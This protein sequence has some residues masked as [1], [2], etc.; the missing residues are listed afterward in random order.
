MSRGLGDVY[1]RQH[2]RSTVF[3]FSPEG[4]QHAVHQRAV[5]HRADPVHGRF[6]PFGIQAVTGKSAERAQCL[7]LQDTAATTRLFRL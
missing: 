7:V 6:Q 5:Q 1:K 3:R 2:Q 4:L